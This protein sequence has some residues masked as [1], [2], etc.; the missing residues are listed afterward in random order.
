MVVDALL[1]DDRNAPRSATRIGCHGQD[2]LARDVLD[3]CRLIV[4][5]HRHGSLIL[6]LEQRM[7]LS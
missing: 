1:V 7:D 6:S 4:R 5:K 3:E 2:D